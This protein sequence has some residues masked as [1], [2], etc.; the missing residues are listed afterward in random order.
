MP[1]IPTKFIL[2]VPLMIKKL[3]LAFVAI[4][5]AATIQ[6]SGAANISFVGNGYVILDLNGGGDTYSDVNNQGNDNTT[7]S[8][9]LDDS[10]ATAFTL[11]ITL[12]QGQ[13]LLLG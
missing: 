1:T 8:F 6:H 4:G 7:P 3:F 5:L 9:D 12:Q 2:E 11:T 13:S 10:S